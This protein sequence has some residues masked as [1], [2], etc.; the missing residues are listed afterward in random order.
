MPHDSIAACRRCLPGCAVG[1]T[2]APPVV[3]RGTLQ[4]PDMPKGSLYQGSLGLRPEAGASQRK[5]G[6]APHGR[7]WRRPGCGGECAT[8]WGRPVGGRYRRA[9]HSRARSRHTAR[10]RLRHYSGTGNCRR[11][12]RGPVRVRVRRAGP[13]HALPLRGPLPS[14][15]VPSPLRASAVPGSVFMSARPAQE[16]PRAA[17]NCLR[18]MGNLLCPLGKMSPPLLHLACQPE[19]GQKTGKICNALYK[20][21]TDVPFRGGHLSRKWAGGGRCKARH[22]PYTASTRHR[23]AVPPTGAP[24]T[25]PQDDT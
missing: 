5:R 15:P 19:K 14:G 11:P 16:R 17:K 9:G 4:G 25:A 2:L 10:S 23:A 21:W 22:N 1:R 24:R 13:S 7:H 8:P 6:G 3:L 12:V 18:V 20:K